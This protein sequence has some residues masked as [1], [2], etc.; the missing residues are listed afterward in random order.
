VEN[1]EPRPEAGAVRDIFWLQLAELG[2][3]IERQSE[4]VFTL[5][6]PVLDYYLRFRAAR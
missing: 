5:Q 1:D 4:R 6:L 2:Q 3:I